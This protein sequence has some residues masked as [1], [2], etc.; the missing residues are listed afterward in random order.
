MLLYLIHIRIVGL[1]DKKLLIGKLLMSDDA[2][3]SSARKFT[4]LIISLVFILGFAIFLLSIN[5]SATKTNFDFNQIKLPEFLT[6]NPWKEDDKGSTKPTVTPP[7]AKQKKDKAN[8]KK[9]YKLQCA[10]FRSLDNARE[11]KMD[12]GFIGFASNI[13]TIK[14]TKGEVWH[15]INLG[16]FAENEAKKMRKDLESHGKKGCNIRLL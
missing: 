16:P 7:P 12:L 3:T 1:G 2:N 4:K 5:G 13:S 9:E 8:A 15:K 6:K 10:S 11:F 14:N